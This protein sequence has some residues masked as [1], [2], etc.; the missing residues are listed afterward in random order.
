[1]ANTNFQPSTSGGSHFSNG[2]KGG[3][4][5]NNKAK[6]FSIVAIV[7]A[8]ILLVVA[9]V[10][11]FNDWQSSQRAEQATEDAREA[12][13]TPEAETPT[14]EAPQEE[15]PEEPKT[16]TVDANAGIPVV[17]WG[18]LQAINPDIVG[19]LQVPGTNINYPVVQGAD[20][21]QYIRTTIRG[22]RAVEG[23]IFMDYASSRGIDDHHTILYGHNIKNGSMFHAL[24][25]FSDKDFFNQHR[26]AYY[27]TPDKNYVLNAVAAYVTDGSDLTVRVFDFNS[28]K[29]FQKYMQDRLDRSVVVADDADATKMNK[30]F[31]LAT[32]SYQRQDGRTMVLY[33]FDSEANTN[34]NENGIPVND[35]EG[36]LVPQQTANAA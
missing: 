17:D 13:I 16:D 11:F 10:L 22:D 7:A 23:S 19:W 5:K 27:V 36:Q 28:D 21:D 34:A 35:N 32:C 33:E 26:T 8:V 31:E 20:N 24:A 14:A 6:I 9:G 30:L 25:S 3:A 15:A 29:D 18:K 1:M 12:L 2:N 4:P